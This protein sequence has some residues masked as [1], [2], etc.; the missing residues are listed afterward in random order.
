MKIYIRKI[1]KNSIYLTKETSLQSVITDVFTMFTI[2]FIIGCDVVF[3]IL[4]THSF[5]IDILACVFIFLFFISK[6]SGKK[7]EYTK[8][9]AEKI[10]KEIL[11]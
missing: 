10:I 8:E 6:L 7:R 1:S 9:E 11:D 2:A 3:S 5:V 4:V